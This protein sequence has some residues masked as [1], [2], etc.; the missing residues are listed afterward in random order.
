MRW[1]WQKK[2]IPDPDVYLGV[3]LYKDAGSIL[4]EHYPE[5]ISDAEVV[6]VLE[7]AADSLFAGG[8]VEVNYD[9]VDAMEDF[10][11]GETDE[12][13]APKIRRVK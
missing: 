2:K 4:V 11:Y 9:D 6:A 5:D 1:P 10:I 3:H 8:S 13:P 12:K 7:V